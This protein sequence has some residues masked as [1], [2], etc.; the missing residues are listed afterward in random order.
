MCALQESAPPAAAPTGKPAAVAVRRAKRRGLPVWAGVLATIL[1]VAG[2]AAGVYYFKPSSRAER[3][4]KAAESPLEDIA[5]AAGAPDE[6]AKGYEKVIE[7][8]GIR[9]FEEQKKAKI[10]F[11]VVNHAATE[12]VDLEGAVLI[13]SVKG[14]DPIARIPLK[15]PVLEAY[16]TKEI[17][18]PFNSKLRAYEMPDWQFLRAQLKLK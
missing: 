9:V 17:A 5:P 1:V 11:M 18:S 13:V 8:T 4:A 14:G 12:L 7:I 2:I 16:E 6:A 3:E 10:K 15:I